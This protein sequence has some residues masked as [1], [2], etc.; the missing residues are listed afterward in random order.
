MYELDFGQSLNLRFPL[1]KFYVW[2]FVVV[3]YVFVLYL[4]DRLDDK[5]WEHFYQYYLTKKLY[6][7]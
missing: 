3:Y 7:K 1:K 4:I 6:P 5:N 2:L